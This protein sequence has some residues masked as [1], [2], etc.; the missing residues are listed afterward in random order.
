MKPESVLV[1]DD[2]HAVRHRETSDQLIAPTTI[3]INPSPFH[4]EDYKLVLKMKRI[5]IIAPVGRDSYFLA[6][7]FRGVSLGPL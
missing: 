3:A 5:Q 4:F 2:E 6:W 1:V 7:V